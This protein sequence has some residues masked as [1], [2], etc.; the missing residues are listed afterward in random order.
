MSRNEIEVPKEI[1]QFMIT[2]AA[3]SNLGQKNGAKKQYRYGNLHIREYD[4]KYLVHTD[5]VDPRRDPLGHLIH[6]APEFL[7]GL[8]CA[9]F[10][11]KKIADAIS[12]NSNSDKLA[13]FAGL[14]GAVPLGY[15][16][17]YIT[18][19]IKKNLE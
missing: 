6:D 2:G 1:R 12:Q 18:K 11:G 10:G 13:L 17:Y 14:I 5:K 15:V 8:A 9:I 4:D 7:V 3:E 19:T 16:G